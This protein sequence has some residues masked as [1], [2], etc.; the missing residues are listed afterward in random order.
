MWRL[1][2]RRDKPATLPAEKIFGLLEELRSEAGSTCRLRGFLRHAV[3]LDDLNSLLQERII[4]GGHL[5][6][7][8]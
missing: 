1:G 8:R 3:A 4:L 7:W 6:G 5:S 2:I